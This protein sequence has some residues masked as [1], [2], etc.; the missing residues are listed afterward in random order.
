MV[1]WIDGLVALRAC[2]LAV[3][4]PIVPDWVYTMIT[5]AALGALLLDLYGCALQPERWP[6]FLARLCQLCETEQAALVHH[7][8]VDGE[9]IVVPVFQGSDPDGIQLYNAH[10]GNYDPWTAA[11]QRQ[12][13]FKPGI[14]DVTTSEA[15]VPKSEFERSEFYADFGVPFHMVQNVMLVT[16]P[17][18]GTS[19]TC[20]TLPAGVRQQGYASHTLDALRVLGPH[21]QQAALFN[22]QLAASTQLHAELQGMLDGLT[23][24][25]ALLD[26]D[27]RIRFMNAGMRA[28][29]GAG[30]TL[31]FDRGV[32]RPRSPKAY[33]A[34]RR[35]LRAYAR[36]AEG[37]VEP[38]PTVVPLEGNEATA[39]KTLTLLPVPAREGREYAVIARVHDPIATTE[40]CI[41]A[42]LGRFALTPTETRVVAL[43]S[44]GRTVRDIAADTRMR[45][46]T[47]RWHLKQAFAKTGA[48]NQAQLVALVHATQPRLA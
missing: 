27:G 17:P 42:S 44:A 9:F 11:Y 14:A 45:E 8:I 12:G 39:G 19:S 15:L 32:L 48:R 20:L 16:T 1:R 4:P 46:T 6:A 7:H 3:V 21:L 33:H 26:R 25:M 24:P 43:L 10:Y 41:A 22:Q 13:G 34:F 23:E 2:V 37:A 47:V 28:L 18:A 29:T 35:A 31:I 30:L 38:A 36:W 40:R 5:D